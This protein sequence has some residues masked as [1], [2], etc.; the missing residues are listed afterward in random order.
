MLVASITVLAIFLTFKEDSY[1]KGEM[2]NIAVRLKYIFISIV[3][4]KY[5]Y[6]LGVVG[7]GSE[8][9]IQLYLIIIRWCF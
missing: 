9:Q 8:T 6:P 5:F 7:R 2:S 1:L 3:K 4:I